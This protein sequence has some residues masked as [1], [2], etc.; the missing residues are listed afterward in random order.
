MLYDILRP[1]IR[2]LLKIVYKVKVTGLDNLPDNDTSYIIS[3]NHIHIW[4]PVLMAVQIKG[5]HLHFM[6]KDVL[7]K[8]KFLN[9]FLHKVYAIPVKREDNDIVA[10]KTAMKVLKNKEVLG[11]FPEGTRNLTEEEMLEPKGGLVLLATRMKVP[12][13]PVGIRG[14]YKFRKPLIINYGKPI[15][16]DEYYSKKLSS[17]DCIDICKKEIYPEIIRLKE[18]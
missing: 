7:F 6:A 8:S 5:R 11:I 13:V 3:G 15:Y 12:I 4:D 10:I 16:L 14:E 18:M 1:I 17:Q 9:W 2:V